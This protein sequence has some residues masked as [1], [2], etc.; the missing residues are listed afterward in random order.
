MR[1]SNGRLAMLSECPSTGRPSASAI[2]VRRSAE[3]VRCLGIAMHGVGYTGTRHGGCGRRA[4]WCTLSP[5]S[6]R[7]PEDPHGRA[8]DPRCSV[9]AGGKTGA[10]P[11][12]RTFLGHY[13]IR[14]PGAGLGF[15]RGL[16]VPVCPRRGAAASRQACSRFSSHRCGIT[17]S[18]GPSRSREAGSRE[19]VGVFADWKP[20][21]SVSVSSF[22]ASG[23]PP[24]RLSGPV[25]ST[26]S[27]GPKRAI[28]LPRRP[29]GTPVVMAPRPGP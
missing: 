8:P 6:G 21:A 12:R 7:S 23:L 5:F 10:G 9:S 24:R 29:S 13:E 11:G 3:I 27:D 22:S 28:V 17:P 1:G 4:P 16:G 14:S 20:E 15:V 26:A 2:G 19:P 18:A 25:R